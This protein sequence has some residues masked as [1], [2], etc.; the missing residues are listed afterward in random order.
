M[1]DNALD[2]L[3]ILINNILTTQNADE[4]NDVLKNVET[5][6]FNEQYAL[7][8]EA[9][10]LDKR[11]AV[12]LSFTAEIQRITF[13]QIKKETRRL[14]IDQLSDESC[15]EL[16][17]QLDF[18]E[19]LE[20]AE[21]LPDRFLNYAIKQLDDSQK[22]LYQQAQ[23]YL[24]SQL[25]HCL[26]YNYVRISESLKVAS[27]KRLITKGLNQYTEDLYAV[28][29]QGVLTGVVAINSL[30]KA[31]DTMLL[32]EIL[33]DDFIKSSDILKI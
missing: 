32:R 26:D 29:K 27:A 21:A 25:G 3:S 16:L 8:I 7:L 33:N 14:L 23:Q 5:L 30:L 4:L 9:V 31:D 1:N 12:W 10:P 24:D 18:E 19:L 20:I 28:N 6:L 11:I 17:A 22:T 2:Q 15:F 13:I